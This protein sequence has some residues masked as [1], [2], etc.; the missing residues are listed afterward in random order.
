MYAELCLL[1]QIK[2]T[3]HEIYFFRLLLNLHALVHCWVLLVL[4]PKPQ[5]SLIPIWSNTVVQV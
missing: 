3:G 5:K 2:A 4:D 1:L